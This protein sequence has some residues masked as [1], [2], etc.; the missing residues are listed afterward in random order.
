[1]SAADAIVAGQL[2]NARTKARGRRDVYKRR[3]NLRQ[4]S[5]VSNPGAT[6]GGVL[7]RNVD[8][9]LELAA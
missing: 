7:G 6:P 8:R 3:E 2:G 9:R 1:M 4:P 5:Q